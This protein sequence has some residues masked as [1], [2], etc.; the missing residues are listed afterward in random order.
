MRSDQTLQ[1]FIQIRARWRII[2]A[3]G[4]AVDDRVLDWGD[5]IMDGSWEGLLAVLLCVMYELEELTLLN[6][7]P[8]GGEEYGGYLGRPS[9]YSK[10]PDR[11]QYP[12]L[13]SMPAAPLTKLHSV[14]LQTFSEPSNLSGLLSLTMPSLS[15]LSLDGLTALDEDYGYSVERMIQILAESSSE[16]KHLDLGDVMMDKSHRKGFLRC[17]KHVEHLT[18]GHGGGNWQK[19][20][21]PRLKSALDPLR[22]NL[23]SLDLSAPGF[24]L[25]GYGMDLTNVPID[26]RIYSL[27]DFTELQHLTLDSH[28]IFGHK[29]NLV[30]LDDVDASS[31][32]L[33]TMLPST[34]ES[35]EIK[36]ADAAVILH[37]TALVERKKDVVPNLR[38]VALHL[39]G[40]NDARL[41]V[42]EGICRKK[43]VTCEIE[44]IESG[45]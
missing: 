25:A 2:A 38:R 1:V 36:I 16:I 15:M 14:K 17:F 12:W 4:L 34:L 31:L 18:Y 23:K 26:T 6:L 21:I 22:S 43:D 27:Q 13:D 41:G 7:V 44:K 29:D 40:W 19:F 9:E 42:L 30:D 32:P 28:M 37:V 10:S 39:I 11:F 20:E 8:F 45:S 5:E 33:L 24:F 3:R 35:L